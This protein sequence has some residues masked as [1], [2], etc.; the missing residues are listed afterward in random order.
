MCIS[1]DDKDMMTLT[2]GGPE[3]HEITAWIQIMK[4]RKDHEGDY[5]CVAFNKHGKSKA[6]GR[7]K[8][9]K[10]GKH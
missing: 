1:G 7:L 4:L 10:K 9:N 3:K 5:S 2:Q 6:T 8:V